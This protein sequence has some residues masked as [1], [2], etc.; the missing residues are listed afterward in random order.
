MTSLQKILKILKECSGNAN[1]R[2]V[3]NKIRKVMREPAEFGDTPL[4][5]A[6][7][8]KQHDAIKYLLKIIGTEQ[9]YKDIVNLSNST[10]HVSKINDFSLDLMLLIVSSFNLFLT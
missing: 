3:T 2:E 9:A 4:H 7:R 10:N 8:H 1:T 6:I 5:F